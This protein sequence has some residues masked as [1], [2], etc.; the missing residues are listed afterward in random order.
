M[1]HCTTANFAV[2]LYVIGYGTDFRIAKNKQFLI[3]I[4]FLVSRQNVPDNENIQMQIHLH[5]A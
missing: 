1:E 3:S 5:Y 4:Q 2:I